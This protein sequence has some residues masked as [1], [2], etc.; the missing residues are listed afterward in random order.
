M[1][2]CVCEHFMF[3]IS[4]KVH[5]PRVVYFINLNARAPT[6]LPL[7]VNCGRLADVTQCAS[8][9]TLTR[10]YWLIVNCT[11]HTAVL[12]NYLNDEC[13]DKHCESSMT[14]CRHRHRTVTFLHS[15]HPVSRHRDLCTTRT[16]FCLFLAKSSFFCCIVACLVS[17]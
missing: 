1:C 9:F 10:C 17:R 15:T 14:E 6:P 5:Q 7:N 3:F 2:V 8:V 16:F 4:V 11:I 13:T 12:V